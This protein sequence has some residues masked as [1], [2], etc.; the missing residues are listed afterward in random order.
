MPS[1]SKSAILTACAGP[2]P[3]TAQSVAEQLGFKSV[4]AKL[5]EVLSQLVNDGV[6]VRYREPPEWLLFLNPR[7]AER[8]KSTW[9]AERHITS[10]GDDAGRAKALHKH[11]ADVMKKQREEQK[12]KREGQATPAT[13]QNKANGKV[14][15]VLRRP[16]TAGREVVD[17]VLSEPAEETEVEPE[18]EPNGN[19]LDPR[20]S[21]ARTSPGSR[22]GS[23]T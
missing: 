17:V 10:E 13:A 15:R 1:Y 22:N 3:A 12:A 4:T 14:G 18:A 6:L 20:I 19:P 2:W 5:R 7:K 8:L 11:Q 16:A 21:L 23:R 9:R